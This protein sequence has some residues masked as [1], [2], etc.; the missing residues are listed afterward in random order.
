MR[1][2]AIVDELNMQEKEQGDDTSLP[3]GRRGIPPSTRPPEKRIHRLPVCT[4]T[5][6]LKPGGDILPSSCPVA[7]AQGD[8]SDWLEGGIAQLCT[9]QE[10]ER[11]T[12]WTM[13]GR[14]QM[15]SPTAS[16][17][18]RKSQLGTPVRRLSSRRASKSNQYRPPSLGLL[19]AALESLKRNREEIFFESEDASNTSASWRHGDTAVGDARPVNW[20]W[21]TSESRQ[22]SPRDRLK[23]DVELLRTTSDWSRASSGVDS[24]RWSLPSSQRRW[25]VVKQMTS[26]PTLS[27]DEEEALLQWKSS[28][29]LLK[30]SKS[31]NQLKELQQEYNELLSQSS[32]LALRTGWKGR[33]TRL[34][35]AGQ[36]RRKMLTKG[37]S[38]GNLLEASTLKFTYILSPVVSVSG[39]GPTTPRIGSAPRTS[40][41]RSP[42]QALAAQV[43]LRR[44]LMRE[45]E[46]PPGQIRQVPVSKG[47]SGENRRQATE[48]CENDADW[49]DSYGD[50]CRAYER[51]P[52]WCASAEVYKDDEGYD[53]THMCCV[54]ATLGSAESDASCTNDDLWKDSFGDG[55]DAYAEAPS[56]CASAATWANETGT[57]ANT[58]CCAC[59]ALQA[60]GFD[61]NQTEFWYGYDG[62]GFG[63]GS[64]GYGDYETYQPQNCSQNA[65]CG[66]G[67][68]CNFVEFGG[69]A[70]GDKGVCEPCFGCP[71]CFECGLSDAGAEACAATC[72]T[73]STTCSY[74]SSGCDRIAD[75]GW[76]A[77]ADIVCD[78]A[79]AYKC[80]SNSAGDVGLTAAEAC[81]KTCAPFSAGASYSG[82]KWVETN[83]N[84][85]GEAYAGEASSE[86]ACI[87]LVRDECPSATIAN[88][89]IDGD[90]SC[91]CQHGDDMSPR[92]GAGW[93]SCLLSS[94]GSGAQ[95]PGFVSNAPPAFADVDANGDDCISEA[96]FWGVNASFWPIG[97]RFGSG[98]CILRTGYDEV[99]QVVM[100]FQ[101][102]LDMDGDQC[103]SRSEYAANPAE[104]YDFDTLN[105][106]GVADECISLDEVFRFFNE[107]VDDP[108]DGGGYGGDSSQQPGYDDENGEWAEYHSQQEAYWSQRFW[109]ET[110]MCVLH[111]RGEYEFGSDQSEDG[112][113]QQCKNECAQNSHCC[114]QDVWSGSNQKLSCLQACMV[115]VRGTDQSQCN[116]YCVKDGCSHLING[117]SYWLCGECGDVPWHEG[118]NDYQNGQCSHVYGSDE[119][120]C[121]DGCA[122]AVE[123]FDAQSSYN[124]KSKCTAGGFAWLSP[125]RFEEGRWHTEAACKA[126]VCSSAP[127]D[128]E[129]AKK[130]GKC[131][132]LGGI[133]SRECKSCDSRSG[134]QELC[135]KGSIS[136]QDVC[137]QE[138]MTWDSEHGVCYTT[139]PNSA[140]FQQPDAQRKSCRDLGATGCTKDE[141]RQ[142]KFYNGKLELDCYTNNY[143]RCTDKESCTSGG[144]CNDWTYESWD[145]Y[146]M[147]PDMGCQDDVTWSSAGENCKVYVDSEYC[148]DGG[149]GPGW[150]QDRGTFKDWTDGNGVD[151]STA[152]CAC[153]GGGISSP[154]ESVTCR[155][156]FT[157]GNPCLESISHTY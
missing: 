120:S 34:N 38:C 6:S 130:P 94:L 36:G 92:P 95:V 147:M 119:Q 128:W 43:E 62:Y 14:F 102:E 157:T 56:W 33:S 69:G 143:G 31:E 113:L 27:Q 71:N 103:I 116:K 89:G 26:K 46:E 45:K 126:G 81:P 35:L 98:D 139:D 84:I 41:G 148:I 24:P 144:Y 25:M 50:G 16:L 107:Y 68:F 11:S 150:H 101:E 44:T 108:S 104:E 111:A 54:C 154:S 141:W 17:N 125:R 87:E 131:E 124:T 142:D 19:Q 138:Q 109:P 132:D 8:L 76:G 40:K 70:G 117:F 96:E 53:A 88:M 28:G 90:G 115:R 146:R 145:T 66:E 15:L 20:H 13:N 127:W 47:H 63:E 114:N 140:C 79:S 9:T 86:E 23:P 97:Q 93:K 64:Y 74:M 129:L 7:P 137:Y 151:A 48:S 99:V 55:C 80:D 51:D 156:P 91:W 110:P 152:C 134:I 30:R 67:S 106:L 75:G 18:G 49:V 100:M 123:N 3:D 58:A 4:R 12:E 65:S 52:G 42:L 22:E 135:V 1:L 32:S 118:Y 149:Y 105:N 5:L 82:C 10:P 39:S 29:S 78:A 133:C 72:L 59:Q 57:D 77:D 61:Y 21:E 73:D 37:G 112:A 155:V 153:G 60:A 121:L 136:E 83:A 85:V 122:V 2:S